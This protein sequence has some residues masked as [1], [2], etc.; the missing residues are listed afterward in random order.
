LFGEPQVAA[1]A[2]PPS[3]ARSFRRAPPKPNRARWVFAS[4]LLLGALGAQLAYAGRE[5][6]L[7]D[8]ALRPW[9]EQACAELH[10]RL[11]AQRDLAHLALLARDIRPHPSVKHALI[12]SA[13]LAN[14]SSSTQPY[15]TVEIAL[16]DADANRIAMRRFRPEEYVSDPDSLTRGMAP[17]TTTE[18]HFEVADPGKAAV[19]FEFAFL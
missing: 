11:P 5:Q 2:K 10:C 7:A 19:A 6:L 3:F 9:L 8:P 4:L 16:A 12:I 1:P 13:R 18:L 17:G 15:P 14:Q